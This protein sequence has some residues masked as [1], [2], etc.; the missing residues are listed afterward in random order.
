MANSLDG[1]MVRRIHDRRG[2]ADRRHFADS[3]RSRNV[4]AGVR[5]VQQVDLDSADVSVP[6]AGLS[7]N[8]L[9]QRSHG[10]IPP[11]VYSSRPILPS[12]DHATAPCIEIRKAMKPRISGYS[13]PRSIQG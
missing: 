9:F 4:E 11:E 1:R 2:G 8:V 6:P 7:R 3:L 10:C 12:I 5:L 13:I